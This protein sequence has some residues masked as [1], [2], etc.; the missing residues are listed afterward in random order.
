MLKFAFYISHH[1]YGHTTRMAALA[2]EFNQFGVFVYIRSAKPDY[3][4]QDLN[5][6]L[7]EKED[8]ICDVGVKHKKNLEPD[9]VATRLSLLQLMGKRQEIIEREVAFLRKERVDLIIT[10]IP[11]LPV[12]AGTYAEIPVFAISNFDWLFIYD[13]LFANQIDLKPV[14]NTIY[15]LYQRVDYAFRLPLS[16]TKSMGSFR[17]IEKT[18][19]LAAYKYPNPD[20]KKFLGIDS[21]IPVLSCSFGGEGEMNLNWKNMCSA[22]P[23]IVI[24]TKELEDIPNYKKVPA[25]FDFSSLISISDILLTKPGYGSF[26][27]A[28][29]SGTYLIYFPRKDYP[30]E[31]VLI[32]GISHYPQKMELDRL[33]LSVS[34]WQN[35]FYNALS[36]AGPRKIIPNKNK[37]VAALILQRYI[38]LHYSQKKLNSIFDIGSNNMNY[39]LCEAGKSRPI[40]TAQIKTGIGS[41][42]KKIGGTIKLNKENLKT[43][44]SKVSNFMV[45]DHKIPSCKY[46]I[47]T[48]IHRQSSQLQ[49]LSVW[50]TK[51]WKVKYTLL[52]EDEEAKLAYL[53]AKDLIPEEQSAIIIDIGGFSTQF[54]YY[55]PGIK[56]NRLSI[57]LGL[58]TI[59]R[60]VQEGKELKNIFNETMESI[61]LWKADHIICIGLTAS[62]LAKIVKRKRYY[63]PDE[64]HGCRISSKELAALKDIVESGKKEEITQYAMEPESLDILY[65]SIHYYTFLLDRFQS[66]GFIVCY[67]GIAAGYNQKLHK[68][69]D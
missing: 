34:D 5:P 65:Y 37:Q 66:L 59:R 10:D 3:L 26:A 28:M 43:F 64:L 49:Q 67:Y 25:D 40:H 4:F 60:N 56:I 7:Y 13:K 27:E 2:K 52:E 30:E 51:K 19:L 35:V 6:Y 58:L 8:T 54:I 14:L 31:E 45:Y 57:P 62:F 29:Q 24:S 44:K 36:F 33:N 53:S 20:L 1:G 55:E 32:K 47:A 21:H 39:A 15:G 48:G 68:I 63:R 50:F 17:K 16:S 9:I 41:E 22:F 42:Y 18:G 11:W 38:E 69:N 61:P 23:G 12:E 46:I